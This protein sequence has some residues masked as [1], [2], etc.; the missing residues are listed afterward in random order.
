M[1][2]TIAPP[3]RV[4]GAETALIVAPTT[5]HSRPGG[6]RRHPPACRNVLVPSAA[7]AAGAWFRGGRR[8]RMAAGPPAGA[9]DGQGGEAGSRPTGPCCG[10]TTSGSRSTRAPDG[11]SSTRSGRLVHR[12][13]RGDDRQGRDAPTPAGLAAI[14]ERN[15][16]PDPR[17]F[18]G[19]GAALTALS[20]VLK[21]FSGGPGRIAI[22]G[23]AG[24]EASPTRSAAPQP[25]G[26]IRI[27]NAGIRWLAAHARAGT[28]VRSSVE[29]AGLV[30]AR[31]G[32][33]S[34]GGVA[35]VAPLQRLVAVR[36]GRSC[37]RGRRRR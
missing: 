3:S 7:D 2:G 31:A 23:R 4:G 5:V 14:Y 1:R 22:H 13:P 20:P 6:R 27:P 9:A 32:K 18:L 10:P 12:Y 36:R 15:R 30:A 24:A 33:S 29:G 16:Q 28:P 26:C 17:G 25:H 35:R 8:A 11:W 34:A 21:S 37:R 19:L